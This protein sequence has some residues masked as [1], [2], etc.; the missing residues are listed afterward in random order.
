MATQQIQSG[1]QN[2]IDTLGGLFARYGLVIVIAWFGALKFT[3]YEAQGIQPLVADSPFMS[4]LYDIFSVYTFSVLLG[5]FEVAA[6]ALI[7]VKPWWPK[8]SVFGSGL[9]ILLFAATISF[10]FTTP[11]VFDASAGGFPLLSLS[12]GFLFKDV[13][14]MGISVWT[15]TD[16]LRTTRSTLAGSSQVHAT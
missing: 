13:A 12:G 6:A 1:K 15:L 3:N 10:L 14:L 7:A 9:A 2:A 5:V 8:V 16:A 11:G 4:W